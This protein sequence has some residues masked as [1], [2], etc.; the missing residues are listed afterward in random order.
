MHEKRK[1]R[2]VPLVAVVRAEAAGHP[3]SVEGRN[4]SAGGMLVKTEKTLEEGISLRLEFQ[5]PG[6]PNPVLATGVVQHVMP[7]SFMGIRFVDMNEADKK[8]IE[9]YVSAAPE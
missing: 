4:I 2:R 7:G 8:R 6:D 9:S 1:F 3:Y 5:L